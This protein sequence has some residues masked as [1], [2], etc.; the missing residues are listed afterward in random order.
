MKTLAQQASNVL[1]LLDTPDTRN[2]E[3]ALVLLQDNKELSHYMANEQNVKKLF[4]YHTRI[5]CKIILL[6]AQQNKALK[7]QLSDRYLPLLQFLGFKT[8]NS[9]GSIPKR[10]AS[11]KKYW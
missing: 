6:L 3:L 4:Q 11:L 7:T 5:H 1:Q 8:I 2:H 9:L 10:V